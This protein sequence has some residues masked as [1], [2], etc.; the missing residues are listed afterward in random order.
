MLQ[1]PRRRGAESP[2]LLSPLPA[3]KKSEQIKKPTETGE[4]SNRPSLIWLD[5]VET[6]VRSKGLSKNLKLL[7]V[8]N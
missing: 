3:K 5:Y 1:G 7:Q 8:I 6:Y 4:N 2:S